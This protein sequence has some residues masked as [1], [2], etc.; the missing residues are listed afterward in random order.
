MQTR[1]YKVSLIGPSE[2]GK[3]SFLKRL[4]Y[5]YNHIYVTERTLGVDVI[6]I[7]IHNNND[8]IRLNIW[9]CAGDERYRGLSEQYHINTQAAI[10][11][12]NSNNDNHRIYEGELPEN[13][14]KFYVDNYNLKNPEHTVDEYKTMLYNMINN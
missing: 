11:F 12:R 6:P 2:V 14:P 10:I 4:L 7:D 9:D 5:G 8:K 1:E 3:S 13:I